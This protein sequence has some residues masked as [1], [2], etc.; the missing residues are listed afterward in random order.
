MTFGW[1]L[2]YRNRPIH[3]IPSITR[4]VLVAATDVPALQ[5]VLTLSASNGHS[6][7]YYLRTSGAYANDLLGVL[8]TII[9][10]L[11]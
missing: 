3:D 9:F 8:A 5:A 6:H 2:Y 10:S 1:Q 4:K 11:E 7:F